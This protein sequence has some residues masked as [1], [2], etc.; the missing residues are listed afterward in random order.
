M[1]CEDH[2][3]KGGFDASE[4]PDEMI[5]LGADCLEFQEYLFPGHITIL[6]YYGSI[7]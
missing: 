5:V 3:A 4:L 6:V 7:N 2:G 1:F